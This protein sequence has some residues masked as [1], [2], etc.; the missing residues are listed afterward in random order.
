MK[1]IKVKYSSKEAS[2]ELKTYTGYLKT[3]SELP[4]SPCSKQIATVEI[5][6]D[7][8]QNCQILINILSIFKAF[9]F[10]VKAVLRARFSAG[11]I[12]HHPIS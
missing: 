10:N 1:I 5:V 12:I 9:F 8:F 6:P 11:K 3:M 4:L 7:Q 2:C